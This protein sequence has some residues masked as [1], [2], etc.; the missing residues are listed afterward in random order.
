MSEEIKITLEE[1]DLVKVA[2][3]APAPEPWGGTLGQLPELPDDVGFTQ[4]VRVDSVKLLQAKSQE[5]EED[6][7]T[8]GCYYHTGLGECLTDGS[9]ELN[10][11]VVSELHNRYFFAESKMVC[12]ASGPAWQG[13]LC[14][15]PSLAKKYFNAGGYACIGGGCPYNKEE[16]KRLGK[17]VNPLQD[18]FCRFM[19]SFIG[20]VHPF[21][22]WF[23]PV[24]IS[25][26]GTMLGAGM[27]L[28]N[29]LRMSVLSGSKP[30]ARLYRQAPSVQKNF[31]GHWVYVSRLF[32]GSVL[33][34]KD[35]KLVDDF[36][37]NVE[38]SKK[39]FDLPD[40]GDI[41]ASDIAGNGEHE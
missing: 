28:R 36:L 13:Q 25:Y 41:H 27:Q 29:H 26:Y 32:P 34:E 14:D 35:L 15:D 5:V 20:F 22:R 10:F 4:R 21:E 1:K 3:L 23:A 8:A 37:A 17:S 40:A 39:S 7:L 11:V 2:P 38:R 18:K 24:Q 12:H 19:L 9:N 6:G 33:E 30:Y 31:N 16:S